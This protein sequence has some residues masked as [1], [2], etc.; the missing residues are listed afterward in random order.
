MKTKRVK[1][2]SPLP[3]GAV[4][5]LHLERHPLCVPLGIVLRALRLRHGWSLRDVNRITH[6]AISCLCD[7]EQG[8]YLPSVE[9]ILRLEAAFLMVEDGLMRLARRKLAEMGALLI[10]FCSV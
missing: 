4:W 6:L 3:L 2:K 8:R 9:V 5:W 10:I 1:N 7:V